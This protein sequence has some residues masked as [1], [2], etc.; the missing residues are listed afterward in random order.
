MP[1]TTFLCHGIVMKQVLKRREAHHR[2]YRIEGDKKGDGIIIRVTPTRAGL[3]DLPSWRFR[4]IRG[5]WET[6][7][8]DV[9]R[10]ILTRP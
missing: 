1:A 9:V 6:V 10:A 4:T 3:P 8:V 2:G 5:S 7:V